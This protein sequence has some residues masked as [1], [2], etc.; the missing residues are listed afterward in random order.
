MPP[1]EFGHFIANEVEKWGSVI[2][3]VGVQID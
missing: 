1:R 3:S 2:R